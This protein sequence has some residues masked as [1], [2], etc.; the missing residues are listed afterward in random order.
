VGIVKIFVC[1]R[2]FKSQLLL[3]QLIGVILVS[4]ILFS[5]LLQLNG[6]VLIFFN[7]VQLTGLIVLV[8]ITPI[9][10]S[11]LISRGRLISARNL[12]AIIFFFLYDKGQLL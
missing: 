6:V 10:W 9:N 11:K 1:G 7:I 4:E 5:V 3:L 2:I 8:V 12:V